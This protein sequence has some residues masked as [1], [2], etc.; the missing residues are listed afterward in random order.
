MGNPYRFSLEQPQQVVSV[1]GVRSIRINQ[2]E[3]TTRTDLAVA[4]NSED[5]GRRRI[6]ARR[7]VLQAMLAMGPLLS[8]PRT[9]EPAKLSDRRPRMRRFRA[10]DAMLYESK[11]PAGEL[12]L[13]HLPVIYEGRIWRN[14]NVSKSLP[15]LTDLGEDI[16]QLSVAPNIMIDI[17]R[18]ELRG[19]ESM[20]KESIGKLLKVLD[21]C[22]SVAPR[23]QFG[24]YGIMPGRDYWRAL[25]G[26][27]SE[28]YSEW[29]REND[30]LKSLVKAVDFLAPSIYTFYPDVVG[31]QKYAEAQIDEARRIGQGK[32]V[33]PVLWP[34]YHD[35]SK[36]LAG[37]YIH[38]AF[39]R[40]QL[41]L[42][43]AKADGVIIWGGY[44]QKWNSTSPWW[45]QTVD[46]LLRTATRTS[47]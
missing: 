11:P 4:D 42:C 14:R 46:F 24:Y 34:Q 10:F 26:K 45:E 39:W 31:W 21:Y 40:G 30:A 33:F 43:A 17:E 12:G 41:D 44:K 18:F 19:A 47:I 38:P 13:E 7:R 28:P 9:A 32:P 8:L 1:F 2:N 35:S 29:R 23:I 5:G 37:T 22:R 15:D 3:C 27:E 6:G 20:V 36:T 25:K 16:R